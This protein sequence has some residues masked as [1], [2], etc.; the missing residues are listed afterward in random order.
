M[1]KSIFKQPT[2]IIVREGVYMKRPVEKCPGEFL[3]PEEAEKST[4]Q[5]QACF[6][7]HP[8]TSEENLRTL[9]IPNFQE[10]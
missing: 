9:E 5:K 7:G 8:V 6:A 4:K 10:T 2:N 3:Y 1:L